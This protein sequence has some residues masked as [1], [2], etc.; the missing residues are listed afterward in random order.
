MGI[1]R[2]LCDLPRSELIGA[3]HFERGG[4]RLD[5]EAACQRRRNQSCSDLLMDL[6]DALAEQ[7]LDQMEDRPAMTLQQPADGSEFTVDI[8]FGPAHRKFAAFGVAE[9]ADREPLL[10]ASDPGPL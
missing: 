8:D 5:L 6:D 7:V 3:L 10:A 1:D 9:A 2:H 4:S